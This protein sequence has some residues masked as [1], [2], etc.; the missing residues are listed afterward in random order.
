MLKHITLLLL[1]PLCLLTVELAHSR[2]YHGEML[3]FYQPDGQEFPVRLF[4]DEY[5]VVVETL[6]GYT[7]TKDITTG[8]YCYAQP[9]PDGM[10]FL[11]TGIKAGDT[12]P[13]GMTL[14]KNSRL[15]RSAVRLKSETAR[16]KIGVDSKGRLLPAQHLRFHPQDFGY[17]RWIP[18]LEQEAAAL[19]ALPKSVQPAPPSGSTTGT[20]I[21]LVLLAQFPDRAGDVTISQS[22]VDAF[23]NDPSYTAFNNATSVYGYFNIQSNGKL[24]YNC[25]VTAY[26]TAKNN[27]GYYTDSS[28]SFGTRAKE[29]I[30]EG[31][32]ILQE[33]GF[34]FTK[35][36]G[37]SDGVLDGV[38][39]FYA[40]SRVNNWSEGLWPHKW[41]SSWTELS[42]TGVSTSF[43]YQITNIGS[44]LSLGTFCHENGHMICDFPD[45]YS[46]DGNAANIGAY[47]L[48]HTSGS[49]HP[50]NVD[51][52][53]KIHAGWSTVIDVT[54]DSHLRGTVE[55]DK[56]T[57]YRFRNPDESREYFLLSLRADSGYEGVYGGSTFATNP[58]DGLVIYHARE[59]GSNTYS[60]IFSADS[61]V[62]YS[63]PYEL[64]VVEANPRPFATPWYIDPTPGNND[65]FHSGDRQEL[66]EAT[67]PSLK[68]W[69]TDNGRSTSSDMHVHSISGQ[70][71]V[72]TFII[73]SGTVTTPPTIGLT[74][75]ALAPSCDFANNAPSQTFAIF[76]QGGGTLNY[77]ISDNGSW[78]STSS[79]SGTVTTGANQ[80]TITY[81]TDGLSPDT[82]NAT[83]TITDP[84]ASNSPQTIPVILTVH[85]QAAIDLNVS[86]LNTTL[87]AD[88]QGTAVFTIANSGGGTLNYS[89]AESAD[90][91]Q[92]ST[93]SGTVATEED[94]IEVR[95]DAAGLSD[96]DYNTTISIDSPNAANAPQTIDVTLTVRNISILNPDGG[97]TLWRGN[98]HTIQWM[99]DG[100]VT[101]NVKIDL[102]KSGALDSTLAASTEN[103][104][105]Y[106]WNISTDQTIGTDYTIRITSVNTPMLQ[107]GS[108]ANFTIAAMPPLISIPY[109]ESF[110]TGLGDWQQASN[111]DFDWSRHFDSTT[112]SS[113]GPSSATDGSYYLYTE[114]SNPNYPGKLGVLEA[115]FDLRPSTAPIMTFFNHMYGTSMGELQVRASSDQ[116]NWTTVFSQS[117]DQG[118]VWNSVNGDLSSLAG[119][120]I[121]VQIIGLTGNSFTSDMAID[122]LSVS[123]S[124]KTLTYSSNTFSESGS[125]DGSMVNS[126]TITHAGDTFTTLA[127]S[128]GYVTANNVPD[129]LT[130]NFVRNSSSQM[131][132]SLTGN[133]ISHDLEDSIQDL[134][135][136][137]AAGAFSSGNA[138]A[139][140]GSTKSL[141]VTF[142]EATAS[143]TFSIN[144]PTV[145]EGNSGTTN[146]QFTV[147]LSQPP[148]TEVMVDYIT[149][150]VTAMAGSDYTAE[151]S[152]L[153]FSATETSKIINIQ[154]N[155]DYYDESNETFIVSLSNNSIGT[156]ISKAAGSG[157]IIDDDTAGISVD[158]ISGNTSEDGAQATFSLVLNSRPTADV[159]FGMS[160]GDPTE[161]SV[162]PS[163][164]TFTDSNWD[165]AQPVTVTGV[166]DPEVDG[167]IGY[168]II[169]A[170]AT[171]VDAKYA[172]M[173]PNDVAVI[174][175]DNDIGTP[176]ISVRSINGNTTESG[177]TATFTVVLATP[178]AANVSISLTSDDTT[179]GIV[180]PL[181]LVATPADWNSAKTVTV[182][183]VDDDEPDGNVTYHIVTSA[184]SSTDP[185]YNGINP[186]DV[187]VINE[188]DNDSSPS[189]FPW[190]LFIQAITRSTNIQAPTAD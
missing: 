11:S 175:E 26:F 81:T 141:H 53:L 131:T 69:N 158:V 12:L 177:G 95:F 51:A 43:Q 27:R 80:I 179:E 137:F 78:L 29:L 187:T 1:L 23:A 82:Y 188:D 161:G 14:E 85:P 189:S 22:Q 182:A 155:G 115:Y 136:Q 138:S 87:Q 31:L 6:D 165:S 88:Q 178:P 86:K 16:E 180:F 8:F 63:T 93:N 144:D 126:I 101:G 145:T 37:N 7:L 90:W 154:V 125:D 135:I 111:D 94:E 38:N 97:E 133:A 56:N 160:S 59:H 17:E 186:D 190:C 140:T 132:F 168:N 107:G 124:L 104:G 170:P 77:N 2:P 55:V 33:D 102:Y 172:N 99:T 40:G 103:D 46:Y 41:R 76:N 152:Q 185:D 142:N 117:G 157:T 70:G 52:Y 10:S 44:S 71:E 58:T 166:E 64:M 34:D 174:N 130:A 62:D 48:M 184:A 108:Q 121:V 30:N 148:G 25:I 92:L 24:L 20:R 3:T 134:L 147:T 153:T 68:F 15:F 75:A 129:G 96:G 156:G 57:F 127:V 66:S 79:T 151:A 5:Y 84:L 45:L 143:P 60:S 123:E 35:A 42:G 183:G 159:T 171:S 50:R 74:S 89:L 9:A 47:S 109:S 21:G 72:V 163:S 173:N 98:Q 113:T 83:I 100:N 28:I 32:A 122:S 19:D 61:P 114:S 91:L 36:D 54:S 110:E 120:A 146:L 119:K 73:G 4:G 139:V 13:P 106:R 164:L 169:T 49:T 128:G 65:G 18:E 39:L 150:D 167:S 112:S 176:G 149:S 181:T 116:D 162:F 67:T 105:L 118:N